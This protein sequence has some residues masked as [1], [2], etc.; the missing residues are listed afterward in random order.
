MSRLPP[1]RP[2]DCHREIVSIFRM[3]AAITSWAR[4]PSRCETGKADLIATTFD[5]LCH[6]GFI[7]RTETSYEFGGIG[8]I[9]ASR[10]HS[11]VEWLSRK[12]RPK[13]LHND[14]FGFLRK[15][16]NLNLSRS[17]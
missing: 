9:D 17:P 16:A 10:K 15:S 11:T 4:T 14:L 7:C 13:R 6:L 3:P 5:K 8:T 2:T 1:E 12:T